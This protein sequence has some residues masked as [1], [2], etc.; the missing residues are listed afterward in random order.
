MRGQSGR[1]RLRT[2]NMTQTKLT[3]LPPNDL[4]Q[5]LV[6]MHSYIS[7]LQKM[8]EI[9]SKNLLNARPVSTA[10]IVNYLVHSWEER[11]WKQVLPALYTFQAT[12]WKSSSPI[13]QKALSDMLRR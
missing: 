11:M 7:N 8:M 1:R 12:V 2:F 5:R 13:W 6:E 9:S 3:P 4:D 10:T